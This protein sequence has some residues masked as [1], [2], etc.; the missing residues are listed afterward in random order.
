MSVHYFKSI[1]YLLRHFSLDHS[2][3][4]I[5][6]P[7][8]MLLAW[9]KI[10]KVWQMWFWKYRIIVLSTLKLKMKWKKLECCFLI[11]SAEYKQ[12]KNLTMQRFL[13]KYV[14]LWMEWQPQW[15]M[16]M[17]KPVLNWSEGQSQCVSKRK[18]RLGNFPKSLWRKVIFNVDTGIQYMIFSSVLSWKQQGNYNISE[19]LFFSLTFY[20][21]R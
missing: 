2:D 5:N 12:N 15:Y 13:Y 20:Q 7:R 6:I 19:K 1:K 17:Q 3:G 18:R 8:A 21:Q 9:V 10:S 4:Q 16:V 14:T 11:A